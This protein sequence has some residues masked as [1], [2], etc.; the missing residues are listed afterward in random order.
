MKKIYLFICSV[1]LVA[2][3]QARAAD[4]HVKMEHFTPESK[5]EIGI[6]I[7]NKGDLFK[8][9]YDLAA[10][11][12]GIESGVFANSTIVKFPSEMFKELS[13]LS[14]L[15]PYSAPGYPNGG[16]RSCMFF[17]K[18]DTKKSLIKSSE[19][20]ATISGTAAIELQKLLNLL[21]LDSYSA[22]NCK[23]GKTAIEST[24]I[25]KLE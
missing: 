2:T 13:S 21:N 19:L 20:S 11:K 7:C 16:N 25:I 18:F 8:P 14:M 9:L 15:P 24:C 1:Y 12:F 4:V 3:T 23:K 6:I 10:V 17:D 22:I 5:P